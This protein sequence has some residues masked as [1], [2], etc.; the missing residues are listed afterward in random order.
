MKETL[1][2]AHELGCKGITIYRDNSRACQVIRCG[3][4]KPC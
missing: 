1:M 4:N 2:L 3:L